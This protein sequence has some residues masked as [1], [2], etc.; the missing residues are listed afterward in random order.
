MST[1]MLDRLQE[2]K[3]RGLEEL[4]DAWEVATTAGGGQDEAAAIADF[5][6]D[7]GLGVRQH[8][9]HLWDY[10]WT[11]ALAGKVPDRRG[12]GAK[13]RSLLERG[14]RVLGRYLAVAR[15]YA[16][17]SGR[18]VARLSHFEQQAKAFPLWVEECLARWEMLDRP[19]KPLNRE[20]IARSQEAYERGEGEPIS[21]LIA[22]LE[23][24]GPLAKE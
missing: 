5:F 3:L 19:R 22:R 8:S 2:N 6:V 16:D 20:R 12:R 15:H 18:E 4:I 21:D 9:L 10:S 1:E 24:D 7:E 17:L 23:Q 11:L 14:G 13:L